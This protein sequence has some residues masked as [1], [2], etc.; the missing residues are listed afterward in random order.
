MRIKSY[1]LPILCVYLF[2]ALFLPLLHCFEEKDCGECCAVIQFNTICTDE[3]GPCG[4]P[5]HHHH[6]SHSHDDANCSV[7][8]AFSQVAIC[9]YEKTLLISNSRFLNSYNELQFVLSRKCVV[10]TTRAPPILLV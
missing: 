7:C 6:N 3:N 1:L 10:Y 5:T 2:N 4:N 8:K 9:D